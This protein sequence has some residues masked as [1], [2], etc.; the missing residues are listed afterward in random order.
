MMLLHTVSIHVYKLFLQR[1]YSD[2]E[3][4]LCFEVK[5]TH[6]LA[7]CSSFGICLMRQ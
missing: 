4:F 1:T 7:E 2:M 5:I 6:F 3:V